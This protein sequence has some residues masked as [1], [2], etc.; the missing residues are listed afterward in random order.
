MI[1]RQYVSFRTCV[2]KLQRFSKKFI[3]R[4]RT[5]RKI[6]EKNE[7]IHQSFCKN[8]KALS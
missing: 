3:N 8:Q 5:L 1:R 6:H 7:A 4:V 2:I